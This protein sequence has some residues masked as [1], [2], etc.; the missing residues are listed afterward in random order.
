LVDCSL[1]R[2]LF[3]IVLDYVDCSSLVGA[4]PLVT[5]VLSGVDCHPVVRW[6]VSVNGNCDMVYYGGTYDYPVPNVVFCCYVVTTS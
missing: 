2:S 3:V 5:D 1:I 6:A 4:D